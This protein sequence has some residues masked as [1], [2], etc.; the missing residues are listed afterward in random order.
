MSSGCEK[1]IN[2]KNKDIMSQTN[3]S[4]NTTHEDA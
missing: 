3:D 1:L 2:K 4:I